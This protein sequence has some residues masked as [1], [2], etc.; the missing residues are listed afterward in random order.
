MD[1]CSLAGGTGDCRVLHV[2]LTVCFSSSLRQGLVT[3]LNPELLKQHMPPPW[4]L[5]RGAQQALQ[6]QR[7]T[8]AG[9]HSLWT[10]A[11]AHRMVIGS[12]VG[13][14]AVQTEPVLMQD[15]EAWHLTHILL[16]AKGCPLGCHFLLSTC[17]QLNT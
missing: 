13:G 10:Q 9:G 2:L 4:R 6:A 3:P 12:D 16:H 15:V 11:A 8:T 7:I 17:L 1:I 14:S 5:S